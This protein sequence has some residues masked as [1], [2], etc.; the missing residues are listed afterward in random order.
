MFC[1]GLS[2]R[3]VGYGNGHQ[4]D[5]LR[6]PEPCSSAPMAVQP[7]DVALSLPPHPF[8]SL[9][10]ASAWQ[11]A[12]FVFSVTAS[13]GTVLLLPLVR[14]VS[15][16]HQATANGER[17]RCGICFRCSVVKSVP[18][19]LSKW[20]L[21]P[22]TTL[23]YSDTEVDI[24]VRWQ[25]HMQ[26]GP[27]R[28]SDSPSIRAAASPLS[29][30]RT[31]AVTIGPW[32]LV[33]RIGTAERRADV[34]LDGSDGVKQAAFLQRLWPLIDMFQCNDMLRTGGVVLSQPSACCRL[35]MRPLRLAPTNYHP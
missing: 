7:I 13:R 20:R 34:D 17:Q 15:G 30:I 8:Y 32:A 26:R 21:Y 4:L 10:S 24:G 14:T 3:V 19:N 1:L 11:F 28:P 31:N 16:H 5:V 25:H 27:A 6:C 33:P 18:P 2:E 35:T 29:K 22:A 12:Q 23:L 9:V